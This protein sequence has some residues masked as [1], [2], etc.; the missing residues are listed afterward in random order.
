MLGMCVSPIIGPKV[1]ISSR[2]VSLL[3]R[4]HAFFWSIILFTDGFHF[5]EDCSSLFDNML[6]VGVC[7]TSYSEFRLTKNRLTGFSV[8]KNS[9]PNRKFWLTV[10]W[11]IKNFSSS[12]TRT[13]TELKKSVTGFSIR[14][15]D[16]SVRLSVNRSQ[17]IKNV[18]FLT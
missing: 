9:E 8:Q 12:K 14:V 2:E 3:C 4:W 17:I 10:F 15:I 16:S 5:F 1:L 11:L 18:Y 6:W 13:I 7:K